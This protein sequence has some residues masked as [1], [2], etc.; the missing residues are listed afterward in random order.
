M[1]I[2]PQIIVFVKRLRQLPSFTWETRVKTNR[3]HYVIVAALGNV[4]FVSHKVLLLL[5]QQED[6]IDSYYSWQKICLVVHS[7]IWPL[8]HKDRQLSLG[9]TGVGAV[10]LK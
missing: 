4:E 1:S 5:V 7:A 9:S 3:R 8:W 2:L 6:E 10:V